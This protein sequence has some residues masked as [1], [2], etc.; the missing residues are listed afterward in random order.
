MACYSYWF[1]IVV[2]MCFVTFEWELPTF[3]CVFAHGQ[4]LWPGWKLSLSAKMEFASA[5][6]L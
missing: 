4:S 6:R 3:P 2:F 5:D 1:F